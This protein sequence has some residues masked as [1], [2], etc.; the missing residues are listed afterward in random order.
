MIVKKI[1]LFP[2]RYSFKSLST[3]RDFFDGWACAFATVCFREGSH[4]LSERQEKESVLLS[5]GKPRMFRKKIKNR[6]ENK[7][8]KLRDFVNIA[9]VSER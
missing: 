1:W 2:G 9:G 7:N 4:E 8:K 3:Y 5:V 6:D